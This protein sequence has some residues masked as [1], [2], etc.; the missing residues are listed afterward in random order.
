M[1]VD[2]IIARLALRRKALKMGQRELG[3]R[4]GASQATISALERGR[5]RNP[6]Y[7][8]LVRWAQALGLDFHLSFTGVDDDSWEQAIDRAKYE[9]F[10]RGWDEH[11]KLCQQRN[12]QG[13]TTDE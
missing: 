4:I 2:A 1:T 6:G 7:M 8:T 5:T 12:H 3:A 11:E 13:D 10:T 9:G